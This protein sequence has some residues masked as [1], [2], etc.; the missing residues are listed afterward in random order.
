MSLFSLNSRSNSFFLLHLT[1][2]YILKR[3]ML[4]DT[5]LEQIVGRGYPRKYR[6]RLEDIVSA[7][8]LEK[9]RLKR[10]NMYCT[11]VSTAFPEWLS[12]L[13]SLQFA[14]PLARMFPRIDEVMDP[15]RFDP[16]T[17]QGS[18]VVT[19]LPRQFIEFERNSETFPDCRSLPSRRVCGDATYRGRSWRAAPR[20]TVL[21]GCLLWWTK[22]GHLSMRITF[23]SR[24]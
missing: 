19:R 21:Y 17:L 5:Q 9:K 8:T 10:H 3:T 20:C 24:S 12:S 2:K 4:L 23:D 15:L 6:F 22:F 1:S 16:N 11:L 7:D 13:D 14:S 18:I